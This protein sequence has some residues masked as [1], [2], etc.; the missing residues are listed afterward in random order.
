MVTL[1]EDACDNPAFTRQWP[2]RRDKLYH[3]PRRYRCCAGDLEDLLM[4]QGWGGDIESLFPG[5][6]C[7]AEATVSTGW[8]PGSAMHLL[9]GVKS[10]L[11]TGKRKVLE[12]AVRGVCDK[13]LPQ[14][15]SPF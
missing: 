6:R 9:P 3:C 1:S 8:R 7:E 12:N 14:G 13:C 4:S 15:K 11:V 5:R 2:S 10:I